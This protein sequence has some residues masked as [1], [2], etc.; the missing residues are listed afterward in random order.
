RLG[1]AQRG[2]GGLDGGA[3]VFLGRVGHQSVRVVGDGGVAVQ[4]IQSE[5]FAGVFEVVL[6]APPRG[7][8]PAHLGGGQ[9]GARGQDRDLYRASGEAVD[10]AQRHR[11]T[12]GQRQGH[13]G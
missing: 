12:I 10:L 11:V 1:G 8:P 3:G 5:G 9:V 13:G 7:Q 6:L 4:G 2:A